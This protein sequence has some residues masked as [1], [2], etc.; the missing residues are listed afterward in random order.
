MEQHQSFIPL[1]GFEGVGVRFR[2]Q[3]NENSKKCYVGTTL[4]PK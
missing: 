3:I 1:Q 2:Q 4:Y